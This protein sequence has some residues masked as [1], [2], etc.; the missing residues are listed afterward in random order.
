MVTSSVKTTVRKQMSWSAWTCYNAAES[1][2]V[3]EIRTRKGCPGMGTC[4]KAAYN[5]R[6]V[7]IFARNSPWNKE[8]VL[9]LPQEVAQIFE[10]FARKQMSL[11]WNYLFCGC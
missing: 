3:F 4:S 7:E 10:I 2:R 5:G 1:P 11:V 8:L 9:M 6:S